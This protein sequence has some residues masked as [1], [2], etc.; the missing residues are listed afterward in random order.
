MLGGGTGRPWDGT[1]PPACPPQVQSELLR[2]WHRWREGKALHN[3]RHMGGGHM[4]QP[5]RGP[6]SQ[7]L[8]L[9]RGGGS[10]NGTSQDPSAETCLAGGLPGLAES[11]F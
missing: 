6:P 11:P 9:S 5:A 10:S 4:A 7:K 8:L 3:E 1:Q 2:R